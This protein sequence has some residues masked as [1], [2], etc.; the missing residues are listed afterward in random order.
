MTYRTLL[1]ELN[2]LDDEQLDNDVMGQVDDEFYRIKSLE[3]HEGATALG[4]G[5]PY[6]VIE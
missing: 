2:A 3:L 4:D 5:V 1:D 6:L